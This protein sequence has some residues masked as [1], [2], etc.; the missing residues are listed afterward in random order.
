MM[1][2]TR[3]QFTTTAAIFPS[4]SIKEFQNINLASAK[5]GGSVFHGKRLTNRRRRKP[6]RGR[7]ARVTGLRPYFF[8]AA[9]Q[10]AGYG[11]V[12]DRAAG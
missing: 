9:P 1:Y 4:S 12:T 5:N 8:P 10:G 6:E 3:I 11:A 7:G 2:H